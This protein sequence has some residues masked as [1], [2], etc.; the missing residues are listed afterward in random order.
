MKKNHRKTAKRLIN[1]G[2]LVYFERVASKDNSPALMLY[3]D[4][5][6]PILISSEKYNYYCDL[7]ISSIQPF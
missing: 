7:I 6:L 5:H 3:F 4:N 2:H 1:N